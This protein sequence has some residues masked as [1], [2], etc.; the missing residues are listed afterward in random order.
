M[1]HS[2]PVLKQFGDITLVDLDRTPVWVHCH[3]V[4]YDEPWYGDT[5]EE[6]FRPWL[7]SLPIDPSQ[8][9]FLVSADFV[10]ANGGRYRG[11]VSPAQVTD[12]V[13][14]LQPHVFIQDRR[15][16]FWGGM[17][18]IP[19]VERDA[20]YAMAGRAPNAIFPL[21]FSG[22]SGLAIGVVSGTL[23]G[24]YSRPRDHVICSIVPDNDEIQ[25][26]RQG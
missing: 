6:T 25:R 23:N 4:D 10:P 1:K 7:G 13:A 17:F 18:A 20:L 21:R 3:V 22:R 5:D 19:A 8:A 11:F 14:S 24:F 15:F 16:A 9:I 2:R 12:D 26:T